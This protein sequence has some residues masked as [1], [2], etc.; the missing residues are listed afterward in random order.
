MFFILAIFLYK[1]RFIESCSMQIYWLITKLRNSKTNYHIFNSSH[2]CNFHI[3]LS[4]FNKLNIKIIL[5]LINALKR[6]IPMYY[7]SDIIEKKGEIQV[8]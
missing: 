1:N 2:T 7:I 4:N 5:K 3:F 6:H 8:Q